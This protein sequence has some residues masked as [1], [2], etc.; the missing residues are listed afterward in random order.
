[1]R[2]MLNTVAFAAVLLGSAIAGVPPAASAA[3]QDGNW[4][5]LIITEKGIATAATATT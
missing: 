1:M 3:I 2:R 4:T 5:V